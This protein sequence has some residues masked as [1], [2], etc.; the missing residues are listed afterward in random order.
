VRVRF[1]ALDGLRGIAIALVLWFHVWQV[2][3]LRADLP[4][5]GGS[6][7]FNVIPEPGFLG[8]DLFFFLSGFC[9]FMPYAD[10]LALGIAPPSLRDFIYRRVL[11]I[12]P[13]YVFAIVAM[14]ALGLAHF[15]SAGEAVREIARHL[16]FIHVWFPESYGSINGVF[17][18]LGVEVQF[19][20]LFPLVAW[21]ALRRPFGTFAA[22]ALF[23]NLY[24]F[25]V[26]DAFDVGHVMNQL[27]G[28]LDLF[29]AGML[30]A[31]GH[32]ML[33]ARRP[34]VTQ[35]RTLWTCVSL[36]GFGLCAVVMNGAF[37]ARLQPAWPYHW[38]AAGRPLLTLALPLATVG[39]LF[40]W[41]AWQRVLANPVL[42]FLSLISYNLYLWHA[43]VVRA[44][45][46]AHVPA[47]QG[48]D[49]HGDPRWALP[50]TGLAFAAAIAVATALTYA[51]E[52]PLLR[53]R[54]FA[55]RRVA[56]MPPTLGTPFEGPALG[57]G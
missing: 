56:S 9:L 21:C 44:L 13:S 30:A 52:R 54:P 8:V 17:W 19:Y 4:F 12:V 41:P 3:W 11:K 49:P 46:D 26:R 15:A 33:A 6:V 43:A 39:A 29:G 24:R 50:F 18:S 2:T 36:A 22:L 51:L 1:G 14:S 31:Y 10:A 5:S 32:R 35:R 42:V 25:G 37:A 48:A 53:A 57:E 20:V 28:T 45:F 16:L 40:A 27:P 7:N 23:A 55:P 38:L 34:H 47:W